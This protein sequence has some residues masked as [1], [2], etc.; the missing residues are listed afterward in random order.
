MTFVNPAGKAAGKVEN[1]S[2]LEYF[3]IPVEPGMDGR[4]W[5]IRDLRG[6]TLALLTVPPWLA[7]NPTDLLLPIEVVQTDAK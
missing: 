4:L 1:R 3:T 7:F 5:A 2:A 6:G